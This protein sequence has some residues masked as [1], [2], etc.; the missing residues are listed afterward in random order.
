M[1]GGHEVV[2]RAFL[3]ASASRRERDARLW[4]KLR[5]P[6]HHKHRGVLAHEFYRL[7]I[8]DFVDADD[9]EETALGWARKE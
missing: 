6:R 8:I 5:T 9:T 1:E 2:I 7:T 4:T 3:E